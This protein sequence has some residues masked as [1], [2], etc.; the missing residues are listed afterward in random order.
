M[1]EGEPA[2]GSDSN[3]DSYKIK[4]IKNEEGILLIVLSYINNLSYNNF[5]LSFDLRYPFYKL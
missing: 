1:M 2:V 5:N 4:L 3:I